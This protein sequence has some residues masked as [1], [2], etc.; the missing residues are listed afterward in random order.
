MSKKLIL[1]FILITVP[2][3]GFSQYY[4]RI[5]SLMVYDI[6]ETEDEYVI[7]EGFGEGPYVYVYFT[8]CNNTDKVLSIQS[9]DLYMRFY[10]EFGGERKSSVYLHCIEDKDLLTI[11]PM[12]SISFKCG[13]MLMI[14]VDLHKSKRYVSQS[15]K[16]IDHSEIFKLILPSFYA[17]VETKEDYALRTPTYRWN[18]ADYIEIGNSDYMM[19][20]PVCEGNKN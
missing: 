5:D 9:S 19:A 13:A 4:L 15:M 12:D 16:I 3:V 18:F 11:K 1:V 7:D 8:L 20:Y 17:E 10:Y 2:I 6:V 14:D